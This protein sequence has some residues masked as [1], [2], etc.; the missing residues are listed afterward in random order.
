M[1][2]QLDVSSMARERARNFREAFGGIDLGTYKGIPIFAAPGLHELAAQRLADALPPGPQVRVL[3][4]GAGGGAM[5]QRLADLGYDVAASDL[6]IE[7]F[8]PR[9]RIAF[10]T[11]DLNRD[12]ATD[13][14]RSFDVV[15]ALELVEHLE[16]PHHFLRQCYALLKPGGTLVISTPNLANP[17]SQAMF[18]RSG[19]FQWFRDEDHR[20]QGHIMPIA[21]IVLRRCWT[22]AGFVP[23]WEGSVGRAWRRIRKLRTAGTFFLAGLVA[24][25]SGMPRRLRGEIYLAVLQK[26]AA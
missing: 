16:N 9:E 22:E 4:L 26:P 7:R 19:V 1:S 17:V 11:L 5:S 21:P 13:L 25:T 24:L 15:V 2:Q 10:H 23:R 8:Q 3:E 6:F 14:A 12:F 20:E 18:V